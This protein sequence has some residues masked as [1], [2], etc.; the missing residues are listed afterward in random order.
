MNDAKRKEIIANACRQW[1]ELKDKS[2]VVDMLIEKDMKRAELEKRLDSAIVPKFWIGQEVYIVYVK[3]QIMP[4]KAT[5]TAIKYNSADEYSVF[6][7]DTV[8]H[9]YCGIPETYIF[10]TK[11]EAEQYLS[12]WRK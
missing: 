4:I 6:H 11:A 9:I 3:D 10:T 2:K 7:Y 5:I 12:K 8:D 1:N